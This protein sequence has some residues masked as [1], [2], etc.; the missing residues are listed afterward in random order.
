MSEPAKPNDKAP[1]AQAE[2]GALPRSSEPRPPDDEHANA[3]PTPDL[4][5]SSPD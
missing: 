4:P 1:P 2:N 5:M 3:G